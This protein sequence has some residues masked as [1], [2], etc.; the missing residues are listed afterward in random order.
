MV[1]GRRRTAARTRDEGAAQ[2]ASHTTFTLKSAKPYPT[3]VVGMHYVRG[4]L[5]VITWIGGDDRHLPRLIDSAAMKTRAA[6]LAIAFVLASIPAT[7]QWKNLPK[8]GLPL[9]TRRQGEHVG[10]GAAHVS[11]DVS[12]CQASINRAIAVL[13]RTSPRI[14]VSRTCR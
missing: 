3:G 7:A 10:A 11:T 6:A 8:D 5:S 14:S 2:S 1:E 12:T 4:A 13:R 9:G